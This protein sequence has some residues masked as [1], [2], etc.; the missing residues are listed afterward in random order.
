MSR[1][2]T[3]I[4]VSDEQLLSITQV[5]WMTL[6]NAQFWELQR[7]RGRRSDV[8]ELIQSLTSCPDALLSQIG[9]SSQEIPLAA[10]Y[11]LLLWMPIEYLS[12][13]ARSELLKRGITADLN[14]Q[15]F[16]NGAQDVILTSVI[17]EFVN[18]ALS[19]MG[20]A[21]HS[22]CLPSSS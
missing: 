17:R 21:D 16:V 3:V 4:K 14:G 15:T 20:A 1:I 10:L 9:E 13:A 22:V 12:R 2:S 5:W 19:H 7:I 6:R 18:R 8:F 11:G